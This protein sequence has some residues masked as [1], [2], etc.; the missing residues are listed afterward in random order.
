M[1]EHPAFRPKVS[2]QYPH[3]VSQLTFC[4]SSSL[5][6]FPTPV[7]KRNSLSPTMSPR[8]A[9]RSRM[10]SML[11]CTSPIAL[12][13]LA[14]AIAITI[15]MRLGIAVVLPFDVQADTTLTLVAVASTFHQPVLSCKNPWIPRL[16]LLTNPHHLVK[17][18]S[19][20][21][22]A[23]HM[24]PSLV[25]APHPSETISSLST[26]LWLEY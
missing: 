13:P 17:L 15:L 23:A 21:I 5:A 3:L 16:S 22:H 24:T 14:I 18:P 10:L 8:C 12:P 1:L 11:V 7:R 19:S 6:T 9:V 4:S 25:V 20:L 2:Y 26:S